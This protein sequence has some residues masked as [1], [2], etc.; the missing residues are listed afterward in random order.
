MKLTIEQSEMLFEIAEIHLYW[1]FKYN[2]DSDSTF[3]SM[4]KLNHVK[5]I[6]CFCDDIYTEREVTEKL[7]QMRA[8][9]LRLSNE[10]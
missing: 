8:H 5:L 4:L 2:P 9:V 7:L 1:I 6:N 10:Y 3:E